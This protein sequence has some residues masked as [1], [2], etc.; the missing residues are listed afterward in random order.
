MNENLKVRGMTKH[1]STGFMERS[2]DQMEVTKQRKL[3]P[4]PASGRR[5]TDYSFLLLLHFSSVR[6]IN[7]E[8]E[9]DY[10]K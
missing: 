7:Q 1:S 6:S 5:H 3:N 10:E 2:S 8:L 9:L 4:Q